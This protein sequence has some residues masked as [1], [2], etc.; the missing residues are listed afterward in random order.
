MSTSRTIACGAITAGLLAIIIFAVTRSAAE[1][2][3]GSTAPAAPADEGTPTQSA[4]SDPQ[5]PALDVPDSSLLPVPDPALAEMADEFGRF[6]DELSRRLDV[7]PDWRPSR[8]PSAERPTFPRLTPGREPASQLVE[9]TKWFDSLPNTDPLSE[10]D[11]AA[12]RARMRKVGLELLDSECRSAVCRL[13]FV[14]SQSSSERLSI[15]R[16]GRDSARARPNWMSF[17]ILRSD[18]RIEGHVFMANSPTQGG[19]R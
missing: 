3:P 18:G 6:D 19:G 4:E 5:Q 13:S 7:P 16:N 10:A 9:A 1:H 14:Y 11:L 12:R 17:T 15:Q 8:A 2:P